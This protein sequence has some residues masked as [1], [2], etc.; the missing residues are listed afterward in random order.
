ML[1][2][3]SIVIRV[4]NISATVLEECIKSPLNQTYNGGVSTCR[5]YEINHSTGKWIA[6]IDGDDW[7]EN[8]Y[9]E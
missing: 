1:D 6:F 9:I 4:Y 8:D 2:M 7:L 5:N 3:V